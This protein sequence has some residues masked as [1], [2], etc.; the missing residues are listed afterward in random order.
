MFNLSSSIYNFFPGS[1]CVGRG[2]VL[3]NH[4]IEKP[5]DFLKIARSKKPNDLNRIAKIG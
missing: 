5:N 4:K 2:P 1:G 3:H